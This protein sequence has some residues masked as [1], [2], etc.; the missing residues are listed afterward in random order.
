M[1]LLRACALRSAVQNCRAA[2]AAFH[3]EYSLAIWPIICGVHVGMHVLLLK[4]QDD[5]EFETL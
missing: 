4:D 2:I 1:V 5:T 3:T